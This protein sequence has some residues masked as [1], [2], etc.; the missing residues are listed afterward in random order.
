MDALLTYTVHI[1][2]KKKNSAQTSEMTNDMYSV[3]RSPLIPA[4]IVA[5]TQNIPF[6]LLHYDRFYTNEIS[7]CLLWELR[8]FG[9][10]LS[11]NDY[12][13]QCGSPRP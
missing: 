8:I 13:N 6:L 3:I 9:I 4:Y 11:S 1:G 5:S 2:G 12:E 10:S 7:V